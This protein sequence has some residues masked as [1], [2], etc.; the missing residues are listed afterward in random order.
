MSGTDAQESRLA[1]WERWW[2]SVGG[3]PGEIV[4]DA[5]ETD[6]AADLDT[7]AHAFHPALPVVDLGCG[8]GRQTRFLA[9]RFGTVVGVDGAP[10][11]VER[12]RADENPPNISYRV[13]DASSVAQAERL[14]AELG[15]ANVYVRGVLQALPA[16]DRPAAVG[17]IRALLGHTGTLFAKELPP[18]AGAYFAEMIE[19][20]G[21]WPELERLMRVIPP[22]QITEEELV[23]LFSADR[24][25][26]LA[27]GAGRIETVSVLP[28][29][30][31]I[32][33]PAI[34]LLARPRSVS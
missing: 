3:A 5:D 4:W 1:V 8:D 34:Y 17:S 24:F 13:L 23:D 28:D 18:E 16:P 2:T 30:D 32:R 9:R 15:D 14:H 29:G 20:H 33:V 6:L 21:V 11:A 12:A 26:V 7:F 31:R 19:R 27:A 22:G 25:E 10:A